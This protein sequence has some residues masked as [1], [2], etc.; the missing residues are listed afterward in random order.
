MLAAE[1]CRFLI[2]I[3]LYILRHTDQG[4]TS[5]I[6]IT[7]NGVAF[8][9][10]ER[11]YVL[12]LLLR[13]CCFSAC[14]YSRVWEHNKMNAKHKPSI[15]NCK[16]ALA[17]L[18]H[19]KIPHPLH[20]TQTQK[21]NCFEATGCKLQVRLFYFDLERKRWHLLGQHQPQMGFEKDHP[22][23]EQQLYNTPLASRS[24]NPG[25]SEE[26]NKMLFQAE[27]RD[28]GFKILCM[29]NNGGGGGGNISL[30]IH[31][32]IQTYTHP[33]A[34]F[35]SAETAKMYWSTQGPPRHETSCVW[36]DSL[37]GTT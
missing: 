15:K 33:Y 16:F 21:T 1:H 2:R 9:T 13:V 19:L 14:S 25:L 34:E 4:G 24:F 36:Y 30:Y 11:A 3:P 5:F 7:L 20:K 17:Y 35:S 32:H 8:Q 23:L 28:Q 22:Q 26:T 31:I 29:K 27:Q 12:L 37:V 10:E 18:L 6:I